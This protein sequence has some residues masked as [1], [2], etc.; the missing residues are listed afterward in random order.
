MEDVVAN[1]TSIDAAHAPHIRT[2]PRHISISMWRNR[3]SS[4]GIIWSVDD[5]ES[6]FDFACME[7][8]SI[9]VDGFIYMDITHACVGLRLFLII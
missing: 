6:I 8:L 9:E 5:Q 3:I 1:I 7:A 4:L 2:K